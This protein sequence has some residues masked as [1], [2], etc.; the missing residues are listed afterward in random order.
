[1]SRSPDSILL[2]DDDAGIRSAL[3]ELLE[4]EGYNVIEASNGLAALGRL[5][6]GFRP[7]A[8]VLDLLMPVMDGWDFRSDQLR[9]PELRDIPVVV[10]TAAGFS[11]STMRTQ[12]G[13]IELVS[14]PL[15]PRD[16]LVA[17]RRSSRNVGD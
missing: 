8:I 12:F 3:R 7:R 13:Q 17:V 11:Q 1:M 15:S 10:L 6:A 16:L 2:V 14:K 4:T 5:R 9:D